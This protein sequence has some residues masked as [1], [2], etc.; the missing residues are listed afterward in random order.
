MRLFI[1][2]SITMLTQNSF[3]QTYEELGVKF[4]IKD[5]LIIFENLDKKIKTIK[6]TET[7]STN[8]GKIELVIN[9]QIE[10]DVVEN[11]RLYTKNGRIDI[12]IISDKLKKQI[13]IRR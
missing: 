8:L 7:S 13:T 2:L 6:I 3:S 12:E 1:L 5:T 4:K 9:Y 10:G 11:H